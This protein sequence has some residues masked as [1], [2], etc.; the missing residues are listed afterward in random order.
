MY[1]MLNNQF[2]HGDVFSRTD[3][4]VVKKR[5]KDWDNNIVNL[6]FSHWV[7]IKLVDNIGKLWPPTLGS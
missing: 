7:Q 3:C 4:V 1:G 2:T 6:G 5:K